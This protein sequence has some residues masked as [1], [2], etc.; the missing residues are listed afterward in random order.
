MNAGSASDA[1]VP[2]GVS[3]CIYCGAWMIFDEGADGNLGMRKPTDEEWV[4]L[5]NDAHLLRSAATL[6]A[7]RERL[8]IGVPE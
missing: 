3:M 6:V 4:E 7:A 1:P 2:G 8:G 5:I